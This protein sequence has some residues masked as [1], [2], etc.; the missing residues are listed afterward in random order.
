MSARIT[1][2]QMR[3]LQ[4]LWGLFC[5]RA[6]L[7]AKDRE[8]RL[9]WVA[10]AIGRQIGSFRELSLV[11]ARDAIRALQKH[12]PDEL[13]RCRV[14]R[15]LARAYGTAGR[16]TKDGKSKIEIRM[17]DAATLALIAR[18]R[19]ELGWSRERLD[20]FLRS[21][22]SPTRGKMIRTL[23]QAN[24]VIWVLKAMLRRAERTGIH[25]KTSLPNGQAQSAQ[26]D[27][28]GI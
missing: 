10:G 19:D 5:A 28:E 7:D 8:A 14:T 25:A 20:A 18:L 24:R 13:V 17:A 1:G 11:E 16:R 3:R 9:G 22:K 15:D 2:G 4:T 21:A 23:D 26:R 27:A 12:L 6:R